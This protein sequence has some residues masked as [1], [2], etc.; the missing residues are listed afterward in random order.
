M[1]KRE[2]KLWGLFKDHLPVGAH[3]QRVETGG[4]GLGI[5][6]V[7][8][9]YDG[10]EIWVELK[11]I[12]GKRVPLRPEQIAWHYKRFAA[13]GRTFIL[14]RDKFDGPRK[15][16]GDTLYLWPGQLVLELNQKGIET[17]GGLILPKPFDWPRLMKEIFK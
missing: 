5:P 1:E 12:S 8:L 7:N 17:G 14:A 13:G 2:S 6:D 10:S 9:C 4:T 3:F 15:G 16:K 11:I